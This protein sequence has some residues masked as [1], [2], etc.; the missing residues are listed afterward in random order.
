MKRQ[1]GDLI[2]DSD[3]AFTDLPAASGP[4]DI[5]LRRG[6]VARD[7]GTLVQQWSAPDG[8]GWLAIRATGTGYLVSMAHLDCA[9]G[10]DGRSLTVS[11]SPQT[12]DALLAHLLLHQVLPLAVSR[13]GRLVLHACAVETPSGAVAFIG[14]SGAGKSTLAAA[15]S[16]RGFALIADDA[17]VVDLSAEAIA[18]WPSAD[19]VR[20]WDDVREVAPG[21]DRAR[22]GGKLHAAVP[23]APDRSRLARVYLLGTP[24]DMS[25][26]IEPIPPPVLRLA[27]LSHLFRLD[28]SDAAESRRLFEAVQHVAERVPSGRVSYPDGLAYLDA[29]VDAILR[30]LA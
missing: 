10:R 17:L 26:S 24:V 13:T 18:V 11:P 3:V 23:V 30:D 4:A 7:A 12:S 6:A 27:L 15:C 14:E 22:A 1:F 2:V 19:G 25:V 8:E 21:A 5:M 9:I 29:A 20:L 28:V 16:R